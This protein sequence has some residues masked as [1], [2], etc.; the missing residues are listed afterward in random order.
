MPLNREDKHNAY[1]Q[2]LYEMTCPIFD[3]FQI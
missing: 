1:T 2:T 3:L